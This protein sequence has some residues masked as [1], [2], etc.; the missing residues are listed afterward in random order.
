MF[1]LRDSLFLVLSVLTLSATSSFSATLEKCMKGKL[2]NE[3]GLFY[4]VFGEAFNRRN[5]EDISNSYLQIKKVS[6][7]SHP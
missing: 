6:K 4:A 2:S 5:V 1:Y 3:L 7:Y